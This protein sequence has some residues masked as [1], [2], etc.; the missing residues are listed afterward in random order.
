MKKRGK[1][2][3]IGSVANPELQPDS[4]ISNQKETIKQVIAEFPQTPGVYLMKNAKDK[5]IYVG[6]AKN[7]RARV[8][9][10]FHESA[11][12]S[13]KTQFLVSHIVKIDYQLT[14]TEVEAFLL[15]ASLIKKFRPRYNIR[16]KDD[17]SYPYIRCVVG[18]EFPRFYLCRKVSHD[19]AL[20][21]G[22]YSSGIAVRETIR[23]LNRTFKIRDC[24][25]SFMKARK[26]PCMTYQIGRCTA[27]CVGYINTK[28]YAHDLKSAVDFLK[29]RDKSVARSLKEKMLQ[30]SKEERY[31]AAAKYR[32]S[33]KAVESIWH[34]QSLVSEGKEIDQDVVAFIGDSRGT[35]VQICNVRSGRQIGSQSHFLKQVDPQS[36][37]EDVRDW[38]VSFLNQYYL[39]NFI[40]DEVI[41]PIDFGGDI[42]KLFQ[43]VLEERG[44]KVR[45]LPALG[46]DGKRLIDLVLA[47]AAKSFKSI[48]EENERRENG[49][50]EIRAK[51]KLKEL[52]KRIE[53]FDVS[54]F[55]GAHSVASQ[56]VFEEGVP[57]KEDY[58]LYKLKT[59]DGVNDFAAMT[60]VLTRRLKHTEYEDPQ[61][62]VVD[63]GKGQLSMA[64]QVLIE[65]GRTDIPVV[66]LAKARVEG[67]FLDSTV[68]SSE[69]RFFLPGRQNP[70]V[71]SK[72]SHAFQI[73]VGIRDEAHR[74]AITF[75]RKLR[76]QGTLS[77][78][79]DEIVGLG[80]KRKKILLK[81]FSSIESI[82]QSDVATLS[83][84]TGFNRVISERVL[85]HLS[86]DMWPPPIKEEQKGLG[87]EES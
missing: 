37:N 29:G 38:L 13:V 16:L 4:E 28:D 75:H 15:E 1:K 34:K 68:E 20:Y 81:E 57:K 52:P 30:A 3:N 17:K 40:P 59:V 39:D 47:E 33:L 8:R 35:I 74:F 54:H 70:I 71:F 82:R 24:S 53:C 12:H 42:T 66:G 50:E 27:P 14:A 62:I 11:D 23:F 78:I 84:L 49:L 64:T 36:P 44:K 73:L 63:G 10:Y 51:L 46:D 45:L 56:V 55:Q 2:S 21:F 58:R 61:L 80:E 18:G 26:R 65:M 9:S 85:L 67:D 7:L 5:I 76:G 19:G 87:E 77:S 25:D 32:D 22:P 83:K 86:S 43:A 6:K 79:L 72:H 60:E 41:V 31:E 48:I 69:E